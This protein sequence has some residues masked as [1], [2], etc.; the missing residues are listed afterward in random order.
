MAAVPVME[1]SLMTGPVEAV[2]V[3]SPGAKTQQ[4][5]T[6]VMLAFIA[7]IMQEVNKSLLFDK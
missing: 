2:M 1:C 5:Y 3:N 7:C 6:S 4:L